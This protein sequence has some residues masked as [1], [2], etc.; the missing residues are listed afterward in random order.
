[1]LLRYEEELRVSTSKKRYI[2]R[3]I[4]YRVVIVVNYIFV[5]CL[6]RFLITARFTQMAVLWKYQRE[7][8]SSV[9][10]IIVI[11][12]NIFCC[13]HFS[14]QFRWIT[15]LHLP[16]ISLQLD[17]EMWSWK[18]YIKKLI[19]Q[20][21]SSIQ[22]YPRSRSIVVLIFGDI[23]AK[24]TGSRIFSHVTQQLC[25]VVESPFVHCADQTSAYCRVGLRPWIVSLWDA[26]T[27]GL[28]SHVGSF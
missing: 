15:K 5:H 1:M 23:F 4:S 2:F 18:I 28:V 25:V 27:S 16:R 21:I 20:I 13:S 7:C 14:I 17:L 3:D 9:W 10:F 11:I 26:L 19:N 22:L 8:I 6:T 24:R 12:N